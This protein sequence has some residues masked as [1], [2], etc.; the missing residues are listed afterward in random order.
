[1]VVVNVRNVSVVVISNVNVHYDDSRVG[2][3]NDAD[4]AANGNVS[5]DP[6]Y[7]G[8]AGCGI[9][10]GGHRDCDCDCADERRKDREN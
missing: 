2:N 10:S 4:A 9:V 6:S 3:G 1:M 8:V 5:D 7:D